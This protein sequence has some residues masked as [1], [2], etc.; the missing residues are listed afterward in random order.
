MEELKPLESTSRKEVHI[1]T[2]DQRKNGLITGVDEV[3]SFDSETIILKTC[4]GVLTITGQNL[5]VNLLD[6]DAGKVQ[7]DGRIDGVNYSKE[8]TDTKKESAFVRWFK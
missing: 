3:V 5:H 7:I 6:V 1:F 8:M 2:I 4:A